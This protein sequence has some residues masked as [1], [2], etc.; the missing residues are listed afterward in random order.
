MILCEGKP[1]TAVSLA[2]AYG[3]AVARGRL[4]RRGWS[5]RKKGVRG[6]NNRTR[7]PGICEAARIFG[8][9]RNHLYFIAM[10]IRRSPRIESSAWYRKVRA[11]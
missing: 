1:V 9:T 8:V 11:S 3:A 7:F 5:Y 4:K 10:G 2:N 6:R